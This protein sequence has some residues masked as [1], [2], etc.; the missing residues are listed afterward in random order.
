MKLRIFILFE[1]IF[2]SLIY[3]QTINHEKMTTINFGG[4]N[5]YLIKT[6]TSFILI[7]NGFPVKRDFLVNKLGE[8]G[9]EPGNL[10]MIVLTHGDHD[11][12]GNSAFL[13]DKYGAKIAMHADDSV[14]VEKGDMTWNRQDKPDKISLTF[15]AI[16][17][18]SR[19]FNSGDFEK[20]KPDIY[21]D[22]SFDFSY[23]GLDA[24][25]I[26]L[27]GHSKGS[28]GILTSDGSLFCGDFLYNL[29]GTPG[30]DF[31][32]NLD[33]FK[34]SVEKLKG[35]K[36]NTFYP[37]HGKSFTMKQFLKKY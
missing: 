21:I 22:E 10:K 32:D 37:G 8:L 34:A 5:C 15:R 28:I 23:Y 35:Y 25:V 26:H 33:D 6:D 36:I 24:I 30:T 4:V 19:L 11:H 16:L 17:L 9:C 12:T 2:Q 3:G 18:M 31:C 1:F 20:F 13:R 29:F 7:D 14:I 27:P